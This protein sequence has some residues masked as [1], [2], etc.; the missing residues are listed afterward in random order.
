METIL[1]DVFHHESFTTAQRVSSF[2]CFRE[3]TLMG[4]GEE[5]LRTDRERG[6]EGEFVD[7]LWRSGDLVEAY[8]LVG[9]LVDA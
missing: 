1:S 7:R 5:G 2:S 3:S 8:P 9:D 6:V 4:R